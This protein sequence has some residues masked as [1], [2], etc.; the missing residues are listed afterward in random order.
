MSIP[1]LWSDFSFYYFMAFSIWK[2]FA[3]PFYLSALSF[4]QI[5]LNSGVT[6]GKSQK[7][8]SEMGPANDR[9]VLESPCGFNNE[10]VCRADSPEREEEGAV[11]S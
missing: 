8:E 10:G 1:L 4:P 11:D 3:F 2:Y 6:E 9:F 7:D 5:R